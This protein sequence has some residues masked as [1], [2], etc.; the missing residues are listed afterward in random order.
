MQMG[1]GWAISQK[2]TGLISC[3]GQT[4]L[5]SK[6]KYNEGSTVGTV[7]KPRKGK[8]RFKNALVSFTTTFREKAGHR[9]GSGETTDESK[10]N[11]TKG[12]GV[13]SSRLDL[14]FNY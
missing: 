5:E 8:S 1:T 12:K 4:T 13:I 11:N 14:T 3:E 7:K 10:W 9:K 6:D 2:A